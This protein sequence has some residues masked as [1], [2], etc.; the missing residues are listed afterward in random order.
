MISIALLGKSELG[1]Y[2]KF[3]VTKG[4]T[5]CLNEGGADPWVEKKCKINILP[6]SMH[7]GTELDRS[8]I[9]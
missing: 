8:S 5:R 9:R 1:Y 2:S 4:E 3:Q 7:G 6:K